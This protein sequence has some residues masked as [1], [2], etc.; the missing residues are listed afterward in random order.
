[1]GASCQG[2]HYSASRGLSLCAFFHKRAFKCFGTKIF[3]SV[4]HSCIKD[5]CL[6]LCMHGLLHPC[7][8]TP[9]INATGLWIYACHACMQ[10]LTDT[11]LSLPA[12]GSS[13]AMQHAAMSKN[14]CILSRTR[15]RPR[16]RVQLNSR[17][18]NSHRELRFFP[19]YKG[20]KPIRS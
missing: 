8:M 10:N 13:G 7:A 1:M 16:S 12:P 18:A 9:P 20:S 15:R 11:L 14:H 3:P 4:F 6:V 19:K 5:V 2:H 17:R